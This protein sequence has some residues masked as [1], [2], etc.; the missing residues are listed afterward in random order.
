MAVSSISN[1]TLT[2]NT[3]LLLKG[4]TEK[5]RTPGS[6]FHKKYSFI[7]RCE[8]SAASNFFD[9]FLKINWLS[10]SKGFIQKKD[11][12]LC[13][14]S[15]GAGNCLE[16]LVVTTKLLSKGYRKI[17]FSLMDPKYAN[18]IDGKLQQQ[19]NA[20]IK[21]ELMPSFNNPTINAHFYA[22][23]DDYFKDVGDGSRTSFKVVMLVDLFEVNKTESVGKTA[24][25]SCL[26]KL[27]QNAKLFSKES[28]IAYSKLITLKDSDRAVYSIFPWIQHSFNN[29]PTMKFAQENAQ[30]SFFENNKSSNWDFILSKPGEDGIEDTFFSLLEPKGK[31]I[32]YD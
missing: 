14:L 24:F 4:A 5:M 15:G 29:I 31:I 1:F 11:T 18:H 13:I 7:D 27:K 2:S 25:E 6:D 28:L 10:K 3:E 8:C 26:T 20:C 16:E 32:Q 21:D 22:S 23:F 9:L 17:D 30:K 12:E 19:F